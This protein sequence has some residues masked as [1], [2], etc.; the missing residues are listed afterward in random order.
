MATPKR[1]GLKRAIDL[2]NLSGYPV[3]NSKDKD[4]RHHNPFYE[5]YK[6]LI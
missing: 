6:N 3:K 4:K 5:I 1:R 2:K